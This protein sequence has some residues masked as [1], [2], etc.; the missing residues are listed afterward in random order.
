LRRLRDRGR[1]HRRQR[2][3][4]RPLSRA[5]STLD[6]GG[7]PP[8]G[9]APAQRIPQDRGRFRDRPLLEQDL[10][11]RERRERA[12]GLPQGAW[13]TT[14][15]DAVM[16][17]EPARTGVDLDR[18]VPLADGS[19]TTVRSLHDRVAMLEPGIFRFYEVKKPTPETLQ[20]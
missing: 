15:G 3:S 19:R 2:P 7:G 13:H 18:E 10:L 6:E 1:P 12:R 14:E 17:E 8:R 20:T 11:A 5:D 16:R 4:Q 9:D